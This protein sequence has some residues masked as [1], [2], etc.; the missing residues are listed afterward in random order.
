MSPALIRTAGITLAVGAAGAYPTWKIG[1]QEALTALCIAG[2]IVL[3]V[4]MAA[5]A[6]LVMQAHLGPAKLAMSF[7]VAGM[8]KVL[9]SVGLAVAA[10][11]AVDIPAKPLFL[12]VCVFYVSTMVNQALWVHSLLKKDK[13]ARL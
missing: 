2:V 10:I 13:P 1:G 12:W 5:Q 4:A 11:L 9:G 8:A 3:A 6:I 7:L